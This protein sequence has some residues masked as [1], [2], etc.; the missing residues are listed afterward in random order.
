VIPARVAGVREIV[1]ATPPRAWAANLTLRYTLARLGV[2]EIW[3]F[4]GA[5]AVA[6]LALGTESVRR[7]DKIVGPGNAWV[8]A[9]K[10][11][12]AGEVAIDGLAGPSEVVSSPAPTPIPSS[13]PPIS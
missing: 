2:E 6:A 13:S 4:G 1:V 3:G 12:L 10:R 11:Q 5:Q 9:A 7:V 8:T